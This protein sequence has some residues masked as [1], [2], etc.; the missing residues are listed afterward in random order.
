MRKKP[1]AVKKPKIVKKGWGHE[2]QI[3]NNDMYCG[4]I[5]HFN[6]GGE[7][8]THYH[9]NKSETWCVLSGNFYVSGIHPDTAEEYYFT[10]TDG[11]IID[12]SCGTIHSLRCDSEDGGD[13][14][15]VSTPDDY[16]DNYRVY[17]GDGQ[18]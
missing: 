13:I 14:M 12:I 17:K 8:S 5:L 9:M 16:M 6:A 10:A 3:V 7:M 15:E 1:L 11:D 4:K 2:V 18:Q